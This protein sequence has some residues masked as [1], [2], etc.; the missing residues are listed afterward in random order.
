MN[1]TTAPQGRRIVWLNVLTVISAAILRWR[2][3]LVD[4]TVE[5]HPTSGGVAFSLEHPL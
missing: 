2:L 4:T 1:A 5:V 3:N